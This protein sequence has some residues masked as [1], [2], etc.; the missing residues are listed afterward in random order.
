[1]SDFL[2]ILAVRMIPNYKKIVHLERERHKIHGLGLVKPVKK[3]PEVRWRDREVVKE[4]KVP[5]EVVREKVVEVVKTVEKIVE[6]PVQVEKIVYQDRVVE[7][8]VYI[9]VPM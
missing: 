9:E 6:K 7:K 8:P 5:V 3:K 4:V 1:M 2:D